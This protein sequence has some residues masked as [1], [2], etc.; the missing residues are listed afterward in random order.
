MASDDGWVVDASVVLKW[1]LRDEEFLEEA[2][3]LYEAFV[4]RKIDLIAP[5]Y[6]RYEIANSLEVARLQQRIDPGG[7]EARLRLFFQTS[8]S[9][10]EDDNSL[11][12]EAMSVACQLSI[13]L[14]DAIYVALAQR[15]DYAFVTADSRLYKRIAAQTAIARWIGDIPGL[16]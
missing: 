10:S 4:A 9:D 16:L 6:A 15:L 2:D 13:T 14:Y 8:I 5:N 12:V 7:A 1:S 11:L 3:A